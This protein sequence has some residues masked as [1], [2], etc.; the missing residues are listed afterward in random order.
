[1]KIKEKI[2][3]LASPSKIKI[4][5]LKKKKF[6]PFALSPQEKI[7]ITFAKK[8]IDWRSY[9]LVI[10]YS[11]L[12]AKKKVVG[13]ANSDGKKKY[14]YQV[15]KFLKNKKLAISP[16]VF[17][18]EPSLG[19]MVREYL[20]GRTYAKI[21]KTKNFNPDFFEK[22]NLALFYLS[23]IKPNPVFKSGI[24]F[25]DLEKNVK[26]LKKRSRLKKAKKLSLLIKE[27]KPKI[28]KIEKKPLSMVIVH[29][30]F[31]PAN[32]IFFKKQ[33]K[34]IDFERSYQGERIVDLANFC[35]HIWQSKDFGLNQKEKNLI[36]KK[37]IF[38]FEKING[39]LSK[40]EKQRFKIYKNYFLLLIKSHQWAWG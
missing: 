16:K 33:I 38:F 37:M 27:I 22:I 29:G 26:I 4:L 28:K 7:K 32:I 6:F 12:K 20:P 9:S 39:R 19:L 30:D 10:I 24:D 11:F 40:E 8:Y 36:E 13:L 35:A 34:I 15:L 23:Q 31:N 5:F 14:P 18:Y 1:M 25:S 3:F 17:F 2:D 21:L